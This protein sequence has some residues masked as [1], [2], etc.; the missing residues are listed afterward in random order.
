MCKLDSDNKPGCVCQEPAECP[1]SVNEYDHV[2]PQTWRRLGRN[3]SKLCRGSAELL[4][5]Q[6]CGTDNKTYDTSCD[7]FATKCKLE[8]TKKGHRLHLDY[9]GSCKR[10]WAA[11]QEST[12]EWTAPR[13]VFVAW[14]WCSLASLSDSRVRG[15]RVGA[16]P[17]ADEGLAEERAAAALWTWRHVTWL[18]HPETAFSSKKRT[19]SINALE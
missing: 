6:V 1:P 9:T 12:A 17:P 13:S 18:P 15:H 14:P 5:L 11:A 19:Q 7:L 4:L 8:G 16:V 2:G 10:E 3:D